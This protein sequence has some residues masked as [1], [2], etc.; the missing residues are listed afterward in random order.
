[1]RYDARWI[2]RA[3]DVAPRARRARWFCIADTKGDRLEWAG[4]TRR[5]RPRPADSG[6]SAADTNGTGRP[7]QVAVTRRSATP[8][9]PPN[10]RFTF[11]RS[12]QRVTTDTVSGRWAGRTRTQGRQPSRRTVTRGFSESVDFGKYGGAIRQWEQLTRPAPHPTT[13][14]RLNP[15]FVEWM[16]GLPAGSGHRPR[17][18]PHP[19]TQNARQRCRTQH[20]T[21]A[22]RLLTEG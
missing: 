20:A 18:V 22:I 19:A 1:M 17:P 11:G 7:E 2:V 21:L 9:T 3:S 13:N 14:G 5:R 8:I 4:P 6:R 16:M 12:A 15:G 10:H